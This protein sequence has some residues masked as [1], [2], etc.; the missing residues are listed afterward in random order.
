MEIE[1]KFLIR[2]IPEQLENYPKKEIVQGYLCTEPV[3]RIRQFADQYILTYK[4]KGLR[5]RIEEE[6]PLTQEAFSHLLKKTDGNVISKTRYQIPD[7]NPTLTIELDQF[8]ENFAGI[9]LAEVEFSNEQ[10]ADQ[11]NPPDWFGEEV[12]YDSAFHNS[13]MSSLE[14]NQIPELITRCRN[15][16]EN[17]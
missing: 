4:S 16:L 5:S 7:D 2:K 1:R 6:M 3:V 12:T 17:C 13:H 10:E 11:Y 8:H 15:V 9:W 14:K